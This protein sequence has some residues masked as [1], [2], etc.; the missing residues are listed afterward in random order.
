MTIQR[1]ILE[2]LAWRSVVTSEEI[3]EEAKQILNQPTEKNYIYRK[4]AYPLIKKG[5]LKKIRRNLYH[6]TLLRTQSS[7]ADRLLVASRIKQNYYIGLHAA[8]E[9]YGKAHSYFNKVHVCVRPEDRFDQFQYENTTYTP[10]LTKDTT[11][12]I[13]TH[14]YRGETIKT[15]TK[16]RLF[17]ECVK[18]PKK[19]GG[20]EETLKSLE[21]LGGID[22]ETLVGYIIKQ[23]NQA[24]L[25]RTGLVLEL[26]KDESVFYQH[27]EQDT[28]KGLQNRVKGHYQYLIKGKGGPLDE[29]WRLYVPTDFRE[30]HRGI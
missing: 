22:F 14:K 10:Y 28:V 5:Y 9:F 25:R 8:L 15:C 2:R 24:L 23:N 6:I 19:I 20:W 3:E 13:I 1:E 7:Q 11:T 12:Q 27:L 18:H 29:R 26:L 4:F 30:H 16:E 21:G 17:V